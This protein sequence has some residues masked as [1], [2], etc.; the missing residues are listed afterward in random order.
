MKK[1]KVTLVFLLCLLPLALGAQNKVTLSGTVSDG[2]TK[3]AL[4]GVFVMEKNTANGVTTDLDGNFKIQVA[5]GAQVVFSYIGFEEESITADKSMSGLNVLMKVE[6][7]YLSEAV[8][9]GY[10]VVKKE[11]LTGAVDHVGSE[12]FEGR[13]V[14]N[15]TQML[16]G[17]VPNLNI[18]IEDGKPGRSANYNI[19]GA[20]SIG[21]GGSALI[22]IDGVEGDPSQINPNDIESVSVLKDAASASIYGS[23]A[24][25]GVVLITTK[26]PEKS[27]EKFKINYST[28]LSAM[29]PTAT[30]DIVTDG[31]VYAK[32]FA[33]S[34]YNRN[35]TWPTSINKGQEFSRV[36][37]EEFR[38]RQL[39]GVQ[40]TTEVNESGKY[41]YYGNEDYYDAIYKDATFAQTHNLSING[42]AG[43]IS[44][45]LSG[46]YYK[47]DGLFNYDPDVYNTINLRAKVNAQ[48]RP[49]L[50]V[51][52][53]VSYN[54]E[55]Y[56]LP[57]TST[58]Q[59]SGNVWDAINME[60]H[61][62][63]PI[64]NPDGT[65]TKCGAYAIGGLATGSNYTN[66]K[67]KTF[68]NTTGVVMEFFDKTFRINADFSYSDRNK[69]ELTK[70]MAVAYSEGPGLVSYLGTPGIDD[71]LLEYSSQTE[72]IAANAYAEYENTFAGKHYFHALA[73]YNYEQQGKKM[74]K[75][76]RYT[77]LSD[78]T[79]CINLAVGDVMTIESEETR[80]RLSGLMF[81][82]NYSYDSRY[83]FEFNGR[84]DGSSKFP[85]NS[86][87]GFFPSA[88]G[89]WRIS[90]EHWFNI[91][92]TAI[93]DLKLRVSY[94]TLGNGNVNPYQYLEQFSF[95]N[96]THGTGSTARSLNGESGSRYT[97]LPSQVP[98]N[99]T[100]ET[101]RTVD[102]GLDAAFLSNRLT[103]GFDWYNRRTYDMY[104]TGP[105]LPDTY[106]ASAP[107]G[108]YADM[109]TNG[110]ELS[111]AYRD[112]WNVLASPLTF[113]IRG[114]LA[115]S[116]AFIT[117][118]YNPTKSLDDYYEGYEIGDVW[119]YVCPGIFS[120][121]EQIDN[122][123]GEGIPYVNTFIRNS[124]D[125]KVYP[126]DP[127]FTDLNENY[128]ID[129]GS[130]T[131]DDPGDRQ[132]IANTHA[133][134]N[135]SFNLDLSWYGVFVSAFFQGVGKRQW[136]PTK[137]CPFWG[138][139]CRPYSEVYKWQLDN[140]W[141]PDNLDAYLPR[142]TGY[143]SMAW[144][145]KPIDRY[146]QDISYIR[147]KNLQIGYNFPKKM[148]E[149]A[150]ISQLSVYLSA[151][152]LWTWSPIYKYTRD[153][154]VVTLCY[155]SDSDLGG[156]K[157]DGYNYPT[158][159]TFSF[160]ITIGF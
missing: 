62:S 67:T 95:S 151:E 75:S 94:G 77:L 122:Y 126:G 108:N 16:E 159:R 20:T 84:Y 5:E 1:L 24:T 64:F 11:N 51:T 131:V 107:K 132:I 45:Y 63:S 147:L 71:S 143:S 22:L 157:G 23:R 57:C 150:K 30:P 148:L 26:N 119:G 9:V 81:R 154:D 146:V 46:R 28:N 100:W 80:W 135:Y 3:E 120:S 160:G 153:F 134:Y 105:T 104:T 27:E 128:I 142:R 111:I 121:Q 101:T 47:Y 155:G 33:E 96:M 118:Y 56:H 152:N 61:P 74:V 4:I 127:I 38:Q 31:F 89:A 69:T 92:P 133:R 106:G 39:G 91:A 144:S 37:L 113:G 6:E 14:A 50:K 48:V 29:T 15:A 76:R 13:P 112:S 123:Y 86:Q 79:D 85:E 83:L 10:G 117:K 98:D 73:G 82:A 52:E 17:S 156:D 66:R 145:G 115:D 19:R 49:W 35:N 55:T 65:L 103:V 141:A 90:K 59:S 109:Y 70:R 124:D 87:W 43:P 36:W 18:D 54:Y 42:N 97:S 88:S 130:G 34:Y 7:N 32:L 139:Y 68:K 58:Q 40:R 158:M 60:G 116:R 129:S 41:V 12:V 78:D 2:Q 72:Y 114:T 53:N 8:V 110:Y 136:V 102:V 44:Y 21:A 25:Y 149:K 137:E 93:S 138:Q 125:G 99:L 140:T